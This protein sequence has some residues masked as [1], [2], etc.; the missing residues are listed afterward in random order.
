M[1]IYGIGAYYEGTTDVS[2]DFIE[3]ELA[4]IGWSESD[5]PSLYQ[6]LKYIKVG[7]IVYIKSAP[8]GLGLKVKGVGIVIDN[9][10]IEDDDLGTGVKVKWLWTGNESLGE[11]SDKYNVRNNTLYEEFNKTIQLKILSLIINKL[12]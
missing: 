5:A 10:F 7:D 12:Q 3:K 1:A 2:E 11:I 9:K 4:C 6:V 8:I